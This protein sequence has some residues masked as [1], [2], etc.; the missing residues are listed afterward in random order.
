MNKPEK[1]AD[2]ET[3]E[4]VW[5]VVGGGVELGEIPTEVAAALK[6]QA[7][8]IRLPEG[9][10]TAY[11]YGWL[12][13]SDNEQRMERI[14]GLG[15]ATAAEFVLAIAANW[16][17]I[18]A[19]NEPNRLILV[20]HYAGYGLRLVVQHYRRGSL[21]CWSVVTAIPGRKVRP[22]EV[23]FSKKESKKEDKTDG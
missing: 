3:P 1:S 11:G 6:C 10:G 9:R 5:L 17:E 23:I 15:F 20:R 22:A 21:E 16:T 4:E 13:I 19:A 7:A 2:L 18:I 12:H 14:K 8:K